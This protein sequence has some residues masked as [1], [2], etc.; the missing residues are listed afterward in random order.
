MSFTYLFASE[1]FIEH[2]LWVKHC[3]RCWG[4]GSTLVKDPLFWEIKISPKRYTRCCA[5]A[6]LLQQ[7]L[8]PFS[9]GSLHSEKCIPFSFS[10]PPNVPCSQLLLVK[11]LLKLFPQDIRVDVNKDGARLQQK[12]L[13]D[14]TP[15][16]FF[17]LN[18]Y[19]PRSLWGFT[20]HPTDPETFQVLT[21]FGSFCYLSSQPKFSY[22]KSFQDAF[23]QYLQGLSWWHSG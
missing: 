6:T 9:Y 1:A 2:L 15:A 19:D 14:L 17:N 16:N 23:Q 21:I 12:V 13:D 10:L 20:S 7:N 3:A 22:T 4:H 5:R 11:M 8:D 18:L